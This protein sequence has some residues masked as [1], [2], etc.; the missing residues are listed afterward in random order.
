[1]FKFEFNFDDASDKDI[2]LNV[3]YINIKTKITYNQGIILLESLNDFINNIGAMRTEGIVQDKKKEFKLK[4]VTK[5]F[6]K[7]QEEFRYNFNDKC[8]KCQ[9]ALSKPQDDIGG[10]AMELAVKYSK[11]KIKKVEK[12][13]ESNE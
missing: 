5:L 12:E 11:K 4:E 13:S 7:L 9:R 10:D 6:N 2:E 8:E 1:M 3:G